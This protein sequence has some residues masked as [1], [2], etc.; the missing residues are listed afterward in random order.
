M[1]YSCIGLGEGAGLVPRYILRSPCNVS[2]NRKAGML[3]PDYV[4]INSR[5]LPL[6]TGNVLW[7]QDTISREV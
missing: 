7:R 2:G 6:E 4:W 1:L 5:E 3:G